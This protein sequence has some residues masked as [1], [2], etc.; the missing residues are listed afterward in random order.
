[1]GFLDNSG[2]IILDAV[3]TDTGRFRLAKG[4]GSFRITK[5]ALGD[6]EIDYTKY[7]K[8]HV[9]GTA[10]Y[11]LE[12]LKTP[13]LEAFTN[14]TST[15]KSKLISVNNTNLL[16]LPV[17]A[18]NE[19]NASSRTKRHGLGTFIVLVDEDTETLY[20]N[21][22]NTVD[23]LIKGEDGQDG[24]IIRLDQGIDNEA[25]SYTTALDA[26]LVETIYNVEMDNRL[27]GVV[28]PAGD[29]Q[30]PIQIDDDDFAIYRFP[31]TS[32]LIGRM[33]TSKSLVG[34]VA[35]S[36]P[37]GTFIQFRVKASLRLNTSEQLFD[38]IGNTAAASIISSGISGNIK[39]IDS[40]IKVEGATTGYRLDVPVRFVKKV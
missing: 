16:Y 10:Y 29:V 33:D 37:R 14:N 19:V 39:Y 17:V 40:I 1:M 22:L 38:E 28:S 7:N 30:S 21:V 4:D 13:V 27:G 23:G 36:G 11:D 6:D 3:L 5:F 31:D 9:S 34:Q 8:N 32:P 18:L 20:K 12:V 15:M 24:T 2:D 25:I 35:I 26:D